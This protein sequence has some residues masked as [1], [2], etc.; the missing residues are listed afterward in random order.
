MSP[1]LCKDFLRYV[2]ES[3]LSTSLYDQRL[4]VLDN[5]NEEQ[6]ISVILR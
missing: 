5:E 6:K 4:D 1:N 3:L 2:R